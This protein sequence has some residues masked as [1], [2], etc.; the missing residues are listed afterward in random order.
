[1]KIA[2]TFDTRCTLAHTHTTVV[3]VAALTRKNVRCHKKS[4]FVRSRNFY[5]FFPLGGSPVA[6]ATADRPLPVYC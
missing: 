1:M 4:A 5:P 2:L 3:G 6:M